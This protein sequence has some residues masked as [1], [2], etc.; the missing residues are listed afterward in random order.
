M[1]AQ[2]YQSRGRNQPERSAVYVNRIFPKAANSAKQVGPVEGMGKQHRWLRDAF[3]RDERKVLTRETGFGAIRTA[4]PCGR[5][6]TNGVPPSIRQSVQNGQLL[7]RFG[8][9]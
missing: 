2:P 5:C 6:S 4:S 1:Q 3:N 7:G 9:E 8:K